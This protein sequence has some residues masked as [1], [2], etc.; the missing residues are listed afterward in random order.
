MTTQRIEVPSAPVTIEPPYYKFLDLGIIGFATIT[1]AI[2]GAK[3]LPDMWTARKQEQHDRREFEQKR[4][5]R[6]TTLIADMLG[7]LMAKQMQGAQE[8]LETL[9][10]TQLNISMGV[11]A[12]EKQAVAIA[13]GFK[14][15]IEIQRKNLEQLE[16]IHDMLA[17]AK[18]SN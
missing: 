18:L 17:I 12:Q 9:A 10:T 3:I 7:M 16:K 2:A 4:E 13:E 5:E 8:L 15:A 11:E 6:Y 14:Q 1:I